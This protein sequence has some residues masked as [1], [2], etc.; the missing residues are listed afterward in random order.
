MKRTGCSAAMESSSRSGNRI[1]SWRFAPWRKPMQVYNST[2]A[3]KFLVVVST[4]IVY[5]SIAFAH[6]LAL[7]PTASSVRSCFQRRLSFRGRQ[8][9]SDR[10]TL[11]LTATDLNHLLAGNVAGVR[12]Y[13]FAGEGRVLTSRSEPERLDATSAPPGVAAGVQGPG[14]LTGAAGE[15]RQLR[16]DRPR[17]CT[18]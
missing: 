5:Q 17:H 18:R 1:A 14:I 13:S 6:S 7:Q 10:C 15:A 2:R 9:R 12:A 11:P 3:K 16:R 4:A 8:Q